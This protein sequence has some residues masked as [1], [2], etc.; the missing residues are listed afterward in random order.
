MGELLRY[1]MQLFLRLLILPSLVRQG[2]FAAFLG[3]PAP[4]RKDTASIFTPPSHSYTVA[5]LRRPLPWA[6][7]VFV[8]LLAVQ[9]SICSA[10]FLLLLVLHVWR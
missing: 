7:L 9:L 2:S 1:V 5:N 8:V 3:Q 4:A 6:S 10:H